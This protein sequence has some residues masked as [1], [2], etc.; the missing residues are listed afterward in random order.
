MTLSL[1][2]STFILQGSHTG[3]FDSEMEKILMCKLTSG[4]LLILSLGMSSHKCTK[5]EPRICQVNIQPHNVKNISKE[6]LPASS[7]S[8][9]F[10]VPP[11]RSRPLSK[12]VIQPVKIQTR[13]KKQKPLPGPVYNY[14]LSYSILSSYLV[15]PLTGAIIGLPHKLVS[16]SFPAQANSE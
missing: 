10:G 12:K 9:L 5:K 1:R 2:W 6:Y 16:T 7:Y 14:L 11:A 4:W 3:S 13:N 8:N 15:N